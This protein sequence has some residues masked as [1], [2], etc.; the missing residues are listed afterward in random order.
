VGPEPGTRSGS[1]DACSNSCTTAAWSPPGSPTFFTASNN[2]VELVT[3][4]IEFASAPCVNR[5]DTSAV[6][7]PTHAW[8]MMGM[9]PY[10]C[11]YWRSCPALSFLVASFIL[12]AY[13]GGRTAT[14]QPLPC[15][16]NHRVE[17]APRHWGRHLPHYPRHTPL[18]AEAAAFL[19]GDHASAG[20]RQEKCTASHP[21]MTLQT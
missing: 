3:L 7:P 21:T 20:S 5:A 15:V 6:S 12:P 2:G 1:A 9:Q 10:V 17:S 13:C 18:S 4:Q 11:Y 19:S 16:G 14:V 8:I